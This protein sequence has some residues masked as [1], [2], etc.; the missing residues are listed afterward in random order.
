MPEEPKLTL[1]IDHRSPVS[2]MDL[3]ACFA[4]L[5]DEHIRFVETREGISAGQGVQLYVRQVRSGSIEA[6]LAALTPL[7]LPFMEHAVTILDF[8]CYLKNALHMVLGKKHEEVQLLKP[9][10]ENIIKIL[11]PVAK[12][13]NGAIHINSTFANH[14]PVNI[15]IN[16]LEANAAQNAARRAIDNLKTPSTDGKEKVLLYWYQARNDKRSQ[17]GDRAIIE[18]IY[19]GPVKTIFISEGIKGKMLLGSNNPFKRAFVVDV[20]VETINGK[21]ALYRITD[22]HDSTPLPEA[23]KSPKLR[24]NPRKK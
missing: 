22:V 11:E 9:N 15:Q 14:A 21:P 17:K 16:Y 13:Q 7:A 23:P 10:Y 1:K 19:P 20:A 3:S 4:G 5:A 2:V 24:R 18:S 6:D 8:A 12:D